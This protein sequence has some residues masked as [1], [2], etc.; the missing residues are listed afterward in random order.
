MQDA[1]GT[2]RQLQ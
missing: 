1:L 2:R